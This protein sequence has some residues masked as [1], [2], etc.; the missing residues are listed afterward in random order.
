MARGASGLALR[1]LALA[2]LAASFSVTAALA[3]SRAP[4]DPQHAFRAQDKRWAKEIV[5]RR[6][7]LPKGVTWTSYST[8]GSGGGGGAS[9][10]GCPGVRTNDSDLTETGEAWSP[11]FITTNRQY[12]I[13][14]VAWIYQTPSQARSFAQRLVHALTHCGAA[15]LKSEVGATKSGR[16]VSYGPQAIPGTHPWWNYRIVI[17][18]HAQGRTIKSFVDTGLGQRGRAAAWLILHG[19]YTQIPSSVEAELVHLVMGR[20]AHP[21]R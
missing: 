12:V 21:P 6:P 15:A 13:V 7:D 11:V 10:P 16:L 2:A 17:T 4:G 19:A 1:L 18:L 8:G 5:L 20:M 14:S 3:A 9:S